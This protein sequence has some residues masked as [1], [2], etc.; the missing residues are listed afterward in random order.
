M[1]NGF[2]TVLIFFFLLVSCKAYSS[3]HSVK[4][5]Y[6]FKIGNG[7]LNAN[8]SAIQPG[9]ESLV[10]PGA[11]L[12][13]ISN[14]FSFTEGP[15]AN[16]KGVVFFSDQPNDKIWKYSTDGKLSV[17]L[18]KTGRSNGMYFDHKGNLI[19]AADEKNEIWCISP[20]GKVTVLLT[21]FGGHRLNGPNDVWVDAKGG[22]YFTDPYYQRP[23]WDRKAPDMKGQNVYYLGKGKKEAVIVDDSLQQPNGIIGTR[24]GK[25]LYVADI[26]GRKTY[27]YTI[28]GD[29][30]LKDRQLFA[31]QG[32][33]GM[34]IDN[35]GN[36]YL[37]GNGVTVY[38]PEGKK[39]EFI[40]TP[41]RSTTNVCFS[42]KH[43]NVLF[44]TAVEAVYTLQMNVKGGE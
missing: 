16:K 22:I 6:L 2:L 19:S 32:S 44:I 27:R 12:Q 33:D 26:R 15:A 5:E 18:E 25:Y 43:N 13:L 10:A 30:V 17:F 4:G 36:I 38:N 34:G 28:A 39:I 31:Q 37:T 9:G 8:D 7:F 42:G 40:S 21:D 23:Y 29:G 11:K 20:A 24:D 41:S 1:K 3:D 14:K 35:K